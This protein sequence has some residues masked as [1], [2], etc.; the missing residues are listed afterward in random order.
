VARIIAAKLS[1]REDYNLQVFQLLTFEL[2]LRAFI[3]RK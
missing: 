2:W 3:D 1:G